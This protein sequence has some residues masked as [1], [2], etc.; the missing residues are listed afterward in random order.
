MEQIQTDY[1]ADLEAHAESL[2]KYF[3]TLFDG[4]DLILIVAGLGSE[5]HKALCDCLGDWPEEVGGRKTTYFDK[6]LGRIQPRAFLK[7]FIVS[8]TGVAAGD[9]AALHQINRQ[10]YGIFF[11]INP[12][13]CG[14][15]CQRAVTIVRH[16]L[17][18]SD[19]S[20]IGSQLRF[21]GGHEAEIV[22]AVHSG[23][24]S[25]HC[26]VRVTPP[27]PNPNVVG[28]WTAFRLPKGS[29]RARWAEYG[30]MAAYWREEASRWGVE[31]DP[32]CVSDYSRVSRVPGFVHAGTGRRAEI[33]R[34]N[35]SASW[36]WR[37]ASPTSGGH[38]V[39]LVSREVS[40][41]V[42]YDEYDSFSF[43]SL[44]PKNEEPEQPREPQPILIT[45]TKYV[46]RDPEKRR[47]FSK[48]DRSFLDHVADFETLRRDGLPGRHVRRELHRALFETARVFKWDETRMEEE[49]GNVIE[50]NQSATPE[51]PESAVE[52]M[53]RAWKA[54]RGIGF[55]LPD[56]SR[57]PEL[58]E[59]NMAE[60]GDRLGR[61]GCSEM[62]KASRIIS[63]VLVPLV[64]AQPGR[65]VMGTVRISS[66]ALRQAA[67]CRGPYRGHG[68]VWQWMLA[69]KLIKGV[70]KG[71]K[72]G[73]VSRLY[74][75]NIPML[76]WLCGFR[77][78]DLVWGKARKHPWPRG[79][80]SDQTEVA[81][82]YRGSPPDGSKDGTPE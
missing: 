14:R 2:T 21:L 7:P 36:D 58:G 81:L 34:L 4:D 29:T 55:Y 1:S 15:R 50:R 67:N 28:A 52:D 62:A 48:T 37:G 42:S 13:S 27:R 43:S 59:E 46:V 69:V 12:M 74:R 5:K 47:P 60:M 76:L 33:I 38:S 26:L 6:D 20:D 9:L 53:L 23:G 11:A 10:G 44:N 78:A 19:R 61:L 73:V 56:V 65:C 41:E 3:G 57:L 64:R 75:I 54:T 71:Y 16:I 35:P 77:T 8:Q 25:I 31:V 17:V 30:R 72:R 39:S 22:T 51:T 49:W 32:L 66:V 40:Q 79:G 82:N 45:A 80:Q 63:K 18:E 24:K 68:E 70:R